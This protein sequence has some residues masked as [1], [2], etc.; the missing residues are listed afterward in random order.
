MTRVLVV[1]DDERSRRLIV[2]LLRVHGY[3]VMQTDRGEVALELVRGA[4]PDLML[5][6]I[7]L[8]GIDGCEALRALRAVPALA[9]VPAVAVTA[10][11]MPHDRER[12]FAAGFDRLLPKPIRLRELIDTVAELVAR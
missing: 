5:L 2:D 10:S 1:E 3:E 4:R 11:A 12:L 6:D 9:N 8:P 7:Q